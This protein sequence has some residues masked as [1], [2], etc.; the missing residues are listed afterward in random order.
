M[1]VAKGVSHCAR[2]SSRAFS[3]MRQR[4]RPDTDCRLLRMLALGKMCLPKKVVGKT[5]A[6]CEIAQPGSRH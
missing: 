1:F 5:S 2:M 6:A 3:Q 4:V